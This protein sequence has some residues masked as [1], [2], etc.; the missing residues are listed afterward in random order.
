MNIFKK[1][2][3]FFSSL[4][5][6]NNKKDEDAKSS[7]TENNTVVEEPKKEETHLVEI[8]PF[9]DEEKEAIA[10]ILRPLIKGLNSNEIYIALCESLCQSKT[11]KT[12]ATLSEDKMTLTITLSQSKIFNNLIAEF[13]SSHVVANFKASIDAEFLG[14]YDVQAVDGGI[15]IHKLA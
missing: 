7:T 5:H 14:K 13:I 6:S 12:Y 9:D 11:L 2:S 1:I 8:V 4:F 3:S 15:V 10:N